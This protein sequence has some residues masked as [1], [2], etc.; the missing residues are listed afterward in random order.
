MEREE[1]RCFRCGAPLRDGW[2]GY[3]HHH[4]QT[5]RFGPDTP[6]N[7]IGTCGSG[8]TGCHG[9]IHAH[10]KESRDNGWIVSKYISADQIPSVPVR[11]WRLGLVLL[12]ADGGM[13]QVAA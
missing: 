6:D 9:W 1:H 10:P 4:R 8:T 3:S 12:T 13:E 11:H 2:P 5:R 7:V